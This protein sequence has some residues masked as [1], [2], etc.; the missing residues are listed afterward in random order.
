VAGV[1]SEGRIC[2]IVEDPVAMRLAC[3]EQLLP[4][5]GLIEKFVFAQHAGFDGIELWARGAGQ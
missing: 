3:Q 2:P 4:G 1:T 5:D